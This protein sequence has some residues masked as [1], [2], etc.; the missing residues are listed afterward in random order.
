MKFEA[1][2]TANIESNRMTNKKQTL[3]DTAL[4]WHGKTYYTWCVHNTHSNWNLFKQKALVQYKMEFAGAVCVRI[5]KIHVHTPRISV[6][7]HTKFMKIN[8]ISVLNQTQTHSQRER[9]RES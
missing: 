6:F 7:L 2:I 3:W 5:C 8:P 4:L 1:R 9:R